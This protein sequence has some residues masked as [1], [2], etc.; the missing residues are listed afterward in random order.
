MSERAREDEWLG[1]SSV[2]W[3]IML[4]QLAQPL[5]HR[6]AAFFYARELSNDACAPALRTWD[7]FARDP[8][9]A[10]RVFP[11]GI[12]PTAPRDRCTSFHC[13][14]FKI[15]FAKSLLTIFYI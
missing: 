14:L 2:Y 4:S 15:T 11:S 12:K 9:S 13:N 8:S 6:G 1:S 10:D 5:I 7:I 3:Q